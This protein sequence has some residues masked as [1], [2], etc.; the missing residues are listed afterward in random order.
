MRCLAPLAALG[1]VCGVPKGGRAVARAS[2]SIPAS[3]RAADSGRARSGSSSPR[4]SAWREAPRNRD[5]CAQRRH[6]CKLVILARKLRPSARPWPVFRTAHQ[7]RDHRI[8]DVTGRRQH[9]PVHHYRPKACLEQ[10]ARPPEPSVD[11]LSVA[12][13][14]FGKGRPQPLRVRR[15]ARWQVDVIGHQAIGPDWG[16]GASRCR[17]DQAPIEAIVVGLEKHRLAPITALGDIVR[18]VRHNNARDLRDTCAS[19]SR[20]ARWL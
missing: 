20:F 3:R 12:P 8:E 16:A 5:Q 7:P 6:R 4:R 10:M 19:F 2:R 17:G 15:R 18:Q 1:R 14:R 13:V 11:R 9:R